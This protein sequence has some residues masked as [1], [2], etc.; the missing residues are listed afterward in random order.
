MRCEVINRPSRASPQGGALFICGLPWGRGAALFAPKGRE[1]G[2]DRTSQNIHKIFY[3]NLAAVQALRKK[4]AGAGTAFSVA[5]CAEIDFR[6]KSRAGWRQ[7]GGEGLFA[8]NPL[9]NW[10][11]L[12]EYSYN[13]FF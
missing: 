4:S 11:N 8:K 6:I 10:C 12:L 5:V 3:L 2:R 1:E 7:S 9:T 13:Y